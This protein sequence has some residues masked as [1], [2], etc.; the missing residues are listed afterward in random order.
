MLQ[1]VHVYKCA[2]VLIFKHNAL[3]VS[4]NLLNSELPGF[5]TSSI[6]R[7]YIY[8]LWRIDPLLRGD[9]VNISCC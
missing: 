6:V 1:H 5:W 7:Y 2:Y 8:I 9:S 3:V 4:A